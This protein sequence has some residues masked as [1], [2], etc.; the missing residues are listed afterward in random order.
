MTPRPIRGGLFAVVWLIAAAGFDVVSAQVPA[1]PV[2]ARIPFAPIPVVGSDGLTHFG[3]ELHITNFYKSTGTLR[4]ERL[5]VFGGRAPTP[6]LSYLGDDV[7]RWMVHPGTGSDSIDGR[8]IPGGMR[9]VVYLWI[10]LK[11]GEGAPASLRHRL[12]TPLR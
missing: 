12:L 8:L 9:A 10:T 2:E 11:N 1:A 7:E 3:Y 5:E 4:L 6:L